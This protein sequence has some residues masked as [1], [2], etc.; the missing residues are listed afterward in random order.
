VS[1]S[2]TLSLREVADR[3]G[4]AMSSVSR[5]LSGHPDVSTAMRA[6]VMAVVEAVDY[7]PNLLASSLR[8]G[9]TMTVAAAVQDISSPS[10]AEMVLGAELHLREA[11]YALLLAGS[12]GSPEHAE[13]IGEFRR[14]RVDGL[15]MALA[16]EAGPG[17]LEQLERLQAPFVLI[18]G[19]L[20]DVPEASAVL[21]DDAAGMR[22]VAEHLHRLGHRRVALV[23]EPT[24]ARP[25]RER[26]RGLEAARAALGI[27]PVAPAG[28]P[29]G[30]DGR[31]ATTRLL[32]APPRPTAIIAGSHRLL[33]GVVGAVRAQGLRIPGDVSLVAF[34]D[35]PMLELAGPPIAAVSRQ[36]LAVG[37]AAANLLLGRIA[38][39]PPSVVTVAPRLAA[40]ESCGPAP[41]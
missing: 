25:C 29:A 30:G 38:G 35:V 16:G 21:C 39:S 2:Q 13:H 24:G 12:A 27:Q 26:A 33:P 1:G 36:P 20:A 4:V 32:S 5:V 11:G 3:A 14:R 9:C 31:E 37:R 19:D 6:R 23:D 17:V 34:D 10:V 22:Q 40:R 41:A 15:L 7:E 28:G 18:D 8:R